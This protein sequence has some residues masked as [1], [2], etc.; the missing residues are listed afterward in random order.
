MREALAAA[1][2][3]AG[4]EVDDLIARVVRAGKAAGVHPGSNLV[5]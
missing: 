4:A 1:L 3:A 5:Q 2:E